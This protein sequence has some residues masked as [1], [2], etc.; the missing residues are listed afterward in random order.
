VREVEPGP[1]RPQQQADTLPERGDAAHAYFQL[2]VSS[3]HALPKG[4][5]RL[6]PEACPD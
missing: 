6:Q 3:C 2:H 1:S 5:I 4:G